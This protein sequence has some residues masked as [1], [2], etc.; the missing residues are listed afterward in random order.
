[1]PTQHDE[2]RKTEAYR[3]L[4]SARN[5]IMQAGLQA[6]GASKYILI[7]NILQLVAAYQDT[8]FIASASDAPRKEEFMQVLRGVMSF[9]YH[10]GDL[11]LATYQAVFPNETPLDPS[12]IQAALDSWM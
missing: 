7:N 11:D 8:D 12:A 5:A 10:G 4:R 6:E 3:R 1:M 9:A 2:Q